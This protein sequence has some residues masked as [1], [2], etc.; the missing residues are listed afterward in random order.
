ML[1]KATDVGRKKKTNSELNLR[2]GGGEDLNFLIKD[3][4]AFTYIECSYYA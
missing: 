1:I 3:V 4:Q 2:G